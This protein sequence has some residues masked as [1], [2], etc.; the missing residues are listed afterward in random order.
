M[1]RMKTK[2][3]IH[4]LA[5]INQAVDYKSAA[6]ALYGLRQHA[7]ARAF[8]LEPDYLLYVTSIEFALK[9]Y[10]RTLG[11]P[12]CDLKSKKMGHYVNKQFTECKPP[13]QPSLTRDPEIHRSIE[14]V[15]SLLQ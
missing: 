3:E 12:T 10:L 1:K 4:P 8:G 5:F 15:L 9:G 14:S 13:L 6:D 11:R 2:D 7:S